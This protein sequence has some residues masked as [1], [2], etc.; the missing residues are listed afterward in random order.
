MKDPRQR[1]DPEKLK[2]F[3]STAFQKS[4]VP[5]KDA[6]ISGK[7][8]VDA[9]L[10]G[11][12]SHGV[13][14]LKYYIDLINQGLIKKRPTFNIKSHSPS[15]AVMD[16]DSGLGFVV[17]YYA[18]AEAVTVRRYIVLVPS[19]GATGMMTL[20]FP[21]GQGVNFAG[22]LQ[23]DINSGLTPAVTLAIKGFKASTR[24]ERT[25]IITPDTLPLY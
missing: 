20:S 7:I 3:S 12:E 14:H 10:R 5:K 16:G 8:L 1:F 4:G 13:A 11:I 22:V 24:K 21:G 25:S 18:M 23:T 17:G 6:D 19:A 9:D 15:I 2:I